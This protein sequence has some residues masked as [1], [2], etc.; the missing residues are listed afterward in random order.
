MWSLTTV[1]HTNTISV[2]QKKCTRII[3]NARHNSHANN[4][5]EKNK[6]LIL[7]IIKIEQLKLVFLFK[8]GNLPKELNNTRNASPKE[9]S[10]FKKRIQLLLVIDHLGT[11]VSQ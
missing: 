8:N 7:D 1:N 6:L 11:L 4:L 3:N 9:V 2:L 5:F 10:K